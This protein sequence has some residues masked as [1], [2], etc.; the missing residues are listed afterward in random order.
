MP[1]PTAPILADFAA[2]SPAATPAILAAAAAL[3]PTAPEGPPAGTAGKLRMLVAGAGTPEA[4]GYY[5][6][7]GLQNGKASFVNDANKKLVWVE[8]NGGSWL[9]HESGLYES[10]DTSADYP[11]GLTY[12]KDDGADPAPTVTAVAGTAAAPQPILANF[13]ALTPTAPSPIFL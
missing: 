1:D 10:T 6:Y 11:D 13:A 4:N 12:V 8:A 3:S 5:D 9:I 7:A 2:A